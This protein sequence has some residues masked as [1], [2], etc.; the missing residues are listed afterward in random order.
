MVPEPHFRKRTDELHT[1]LVTRVIPYR[2]RLE[3]LAV[4][5]ILERFGMNGLVGLAAD[6]SAAPHQGSVGCPSSPRFDHRRLQGRIRRPQD[7]RQSHLD[8]VA[9][10]AGSIAIASAFVILA[11]S[12]RI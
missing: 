6:Y 10:R 4:A 3:N 11:K 7:I 5:A 9:S 12:S 2:S 1:R 8:Y